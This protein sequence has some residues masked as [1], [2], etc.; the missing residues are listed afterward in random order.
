MFKKRLHYPFKV[1]PLLFL[2][3]THDS[4]A[5]QKRHGTK[6][7]KYHTHTDIYFWCV[8][9]RDT[10][11]TSNLYG[12][13]S[14]GLETWSGTEGWGESQWSRPERGTGGGLSWHSH[15][16]QSVITQTMSNY[17]PILPEENIQMWLRNILVLIFVHVLLP[18]THWSSSYQRFSSAQGW[19]ARSAPPECAHCSPRRDPPGN[20]SPPIPLRSGELWSGWPCRCLQLC[21]CNKHDRCTHTKSRQR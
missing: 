19:W 13:M 17:T 15:K 18:Y 14:Q 20:S 2:A 10:D 16:S 3:L 1:V 4:T 11:T 12:E 5:L 7:Y 21:T 6:D 9:L 8:C